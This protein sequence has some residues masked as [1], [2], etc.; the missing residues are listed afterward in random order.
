MGKARIDLKPRV[1]VEDVRAMGPGKAD[2]LTLIDREG[3]ISGAAKAMKMSYR[4]AWL[5]VEAMNSAFR[6]PLVATAAGGSGGGGAQ[7]TD[8]GR[9]LLE[10]YRRLQ[11]AVTETAASFEAEFQAHLK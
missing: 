4:R 11:A 5:L 2:L 10:I 6:R 8:E 3:S 1:M 7:L 9:E